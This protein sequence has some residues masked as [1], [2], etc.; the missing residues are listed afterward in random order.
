MRSLKTIYFDT[1]IGIV[2]RFVYTLL[3]VLAGATQGALH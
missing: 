3:E 2:R 1:Q